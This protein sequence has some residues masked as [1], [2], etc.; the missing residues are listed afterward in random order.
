MKHGS[1]AQRAEI[2]LRGDGAITGEVFGSVGHVVVVG[3]GADG[4]RIL[5]LGGVLDR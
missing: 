3:V 5:C 4:E 1:A 2:A